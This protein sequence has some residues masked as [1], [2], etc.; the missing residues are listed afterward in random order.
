MLSKKAKLKCHVVFDLDNCG[1][2]P[3]LDLALA[4]RAARN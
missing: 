1:V 4:D 2:E 3:G